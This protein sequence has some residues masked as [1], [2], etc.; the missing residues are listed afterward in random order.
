MQEFI[1]CFGIVFVG[2]GH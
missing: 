1:K 2:V